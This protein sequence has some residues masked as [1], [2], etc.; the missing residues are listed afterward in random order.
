[1]LQKQQ[2][3]LQ[4]ISQSTFYILKYIFTLSSKLLHT[5]N[6]LQTSSHNR[7]LLSSCSL[8]CG[9]QKHDSLHSNPQLPICTFVH[10]FNNGVSV[11]I[12]N[13]LVFSMLMLVMLRTFSCPQAA[14]K[15]MYDL[16]SSVCNMIL[17]QYI[18][19][20]NMEP[21]ILGLSLHSKSLH[22]LIK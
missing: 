9:Q 3:L 2:H 18:Y 22:I 11:L 15:K 14:L 12:A 16:R 4:C 19:F 10:I 20:S 17:S 13:T 5:I 1:M 6:A 8:F 21:H 7:R